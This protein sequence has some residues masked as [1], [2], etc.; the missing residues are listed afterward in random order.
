MKKSFQLDNFTDSTLK[1][2]LDYSLENRKIYFKLVNFRF[3]MY[4]G[5]VIDIDELKKLKIYESLILLPEDYFEKLELFGRKN[6][7]LVLK[8]NKGRYH[9]KICLKCLKA[10]A[11]EE[12]EKSQNSEELKRLLHL[13]LNSETGHD[14]DYI[15]DLEIKI[16]KETKQEKQD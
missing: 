10:Y 8:D 9:S 15:D 7:L 11:L 14:G 12:A 5:N 2:N 13:V 3:R 4:A 1:K 6:T 16:M